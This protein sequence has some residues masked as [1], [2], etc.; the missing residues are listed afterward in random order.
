MYHVP[1][2]MTTIPRSPTISIS[3]ETPSV[4]TA[5]PPKTTRRPRTRWRID[6]WR[7][8][9]FGDGLGLR[10]SANPGSS[11]DSWASSS[12]NI[13]R[14]YSE[15]AM[16]SPLSSAYPSRISRRHE[17]QKSCGPPRCHSFWGDGVHSPPG[18]RDLPR[19]RGLLGFTGFLR[20]IRLPRFRGASPCQLRCAS[21]C[22]RR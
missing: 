18:E 10:V 8:A 7:A 5:M 12:S 19:S 4:R 13:F 9:A 21:P 2:N 22:R 17:R 1:R 11:S 15:R 6:T 14:S 20:F 3:A 16:G